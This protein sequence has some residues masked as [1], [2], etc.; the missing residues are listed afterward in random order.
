LLTIITC[1][2][3]PKFSIV[4]KVRGTE[5]AVVVKQENVSA[6]VFPRH[7]KSY[8]LHRQIMQPHHHQQ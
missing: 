8:S 1:L 6:C 2:Y 3:F 7:L 5:N 4:F